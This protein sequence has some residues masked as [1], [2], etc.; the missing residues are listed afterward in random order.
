MP[1]R[2]LPAAVQRLVKLRAK[3]LC[4]YCLASSKFSFHSFRTDH[5]IPFSKGGTDDPHNLANTCDFCNGSKH[6]KTEAPDP[7]TGAIVP[8][9][10]PRNDLWA[11]HFTW[12][13]DF[14]IIIGITP[15][16]R[17]TVACLKMNKQEA[18]NLRAAL[19]NFGVHPSK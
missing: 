16:G 6:K 1:N 8:L 11:A 9:F 14:T 7:L 3:N 19:R 18:R 17:A 4:E 2:R 5:I 13:D 12:S 15:I 10:H